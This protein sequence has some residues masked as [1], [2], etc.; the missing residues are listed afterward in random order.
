VHLW[1]A[2]TR[3]TKLWRWSFVAELNELTAAAVPAHDFVHGGG[4][5]RRRAEGARDE[6]LCFAPACPV[7]HRASTA[8]C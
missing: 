2:D 6:T 4:L 7:R 1:T 5:G 8:T 3:Q